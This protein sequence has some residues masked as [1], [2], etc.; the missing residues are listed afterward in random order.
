MFVIFALVLIL[1]AQPLRVSEAF[2]S[3][4]SPSSPKVAAE[5][6]QQP[7]HLLNAVSASA[8]PQ[9]GA[10]GAYWANSPLRV[11]PPWSYDDE[12]QLSREPGFSAAA[13]YRRPPLPDQPHRRLQA[14]GNYLV[15]AAISVENSNALTDDTLAVFFTP[16]VA[17]IAFQFLGYAAEPI[18]QCQGL[19]QRCRGNFFIPQQLNDTCPT[20][21]GS[22]PVNFGVCSG[23]VINMTT[24]QTAPQLTYIELPLSG[25]ATSC[26]RLVVRMRRRRMLPRRSSAASVEPATT[27]LSRIPPNRHRA[28]V[29]L[30]IVLS[31]A[32]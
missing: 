5:S 20:M 11:R 3:A 23:Q 21:R 13:L 32:D 19:G 4:P 8:S 28:P 18:P 25:T 17:N 6:Q 12:R 26:V 30:P 22:D 1:L 2:A 9:D 16:D 29:P 31:A 14:P 10:I 7:L 15:S 27:E 24:C